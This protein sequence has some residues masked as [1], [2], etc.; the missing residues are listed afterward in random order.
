[1]PAGSSICQ[2][3]E[4]NAVTSQRLAEDLIDRVFRLDEAPSPKG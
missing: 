1:M 2:A 3:R 4:S